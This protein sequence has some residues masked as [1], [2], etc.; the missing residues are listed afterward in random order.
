MGCFNVTCQLA[1]RKLTFFSPSLIVRGMLKRCN[2]GLR[3]TG[4]FYRRDRRMTYP[5]R[6]IAIVICCFIF[7]GGA[8]AHE[9]AS[10]LRPF[11]DFRL[12]VPNCVCVQ[13]EGCP[14]CRNLLGLNATL[15][16][17]I[18]VEPGTCTR[19]NRTR[20]VTVDFRWGHGASA[21]DG[22]LIV[23]HRRDD[24]KVSYY[25]QGKELFVA[26]GDSRGNV[27]V[28]DSAGF[29]DKMRKRSHPHVEATILNLG[30]HE[31]VRAGFGACEGG[32]EA[33][34]CPITEEIFKVSTAIFATLLCVENPLACGAIVGGKD[35]LDNQYDQWCD[36]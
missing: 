14:C 33:D 27:T 34:V 23:R 35:E 36:V 7:L 9:E 12:C 3:L 1:L 26:S 11:D 10:G 16:A 24:A 13:S 5:A 2:D 19:S 21:T 29:E 31:A 20:V 8:E 25:R 28:Q 22:R 6:R 4:N 18:L 30:V 32:T 15:P 17:T